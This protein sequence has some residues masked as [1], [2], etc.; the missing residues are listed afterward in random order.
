MPET[1]E[2]EIILKRRNPDIASKLSAWELIRDSFLGG[3]SYI[4]KN[5]L[6]Q[7][8]KEN[9]F[10]YENRKRR[11]VFLNHTSPI[12][13]ALT[14]LIFDTTPSRDVPDSL[15][16]FLEK[17]NHRQSMDE[18]MQ[19]VATKSLLC[20]CAVLVD[21]PTFDPEIIKTQAD[22]NEQGLRPYC[23]L[24][25]LGQIRDFSIDEKGS[26]L[27][28]LLDNSYLED[29]DPFQERTNVV[30]YR[31]WTKDYYQDFTRTKDGKVIA[32]DPVQHSLGRVPLIFVSWSDNE[33]GPI[34]QTV[35]EDIAIIDRKIYNL[36]SV[37]D[38]VIY[39]GAFKIFIYPGVLPEKLEKEGIGSLSFITYDKESGS[40]P[41]FIGPGIEDLTGLGI[42]VE[43]L[44]K[45]ILQ[46]VGLD[47]DQE[48]TGPQSG[49]A[50]SLE[51]RE[52]KAFLHSGATRL[53]KCEREIF[54]LFALWQKSSVSKD[55]IKI[56]YQKKFETIDIAETV[57]TLLTVFDSLNYSAVKKKIA[58]EIINKVFPDLSESE[59]SKL[60]SEIDSTDT[61]KL[62]GFM[63][64]FFNAES[65]H[66]AS[67]SDMEEKNQESQNTRGAAPTQTQTRTANSRDKVA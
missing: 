24:Y 59:K 16:P 25:D 29:E 3:L 13:E 49:I 32:N 45:K 14:G 20:T 8:S 34:N 42:V 31:L 53:E 19:E 38:E 41:S 67:S 4:D 37:E 43:R 56:S 63:E 66:T 15:K 5:H 17:V 27:W 7:Y 55:Q 35:F 47:K 28:V 52:A 23:V 40:A 30:E 6:F 46:K 39:S 2:Y 1:I 10:S 51:F 33:S 65:S 21:S 11:S 44:C 57:K 54:E 9:S 18:F 48:K 12:V 26:L 64:K 61:E 22:I 50:K 60:Y 62:P 58:K 36:L